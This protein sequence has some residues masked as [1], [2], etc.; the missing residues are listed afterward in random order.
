MEDHGNFLKS[1]LN[2]LKTGNLNEM[3]KMLN[4]LSHNSNKGFVNVSPKTYHK[5]KIETIANLLFNNNF[6]EL[7]RIL[8]EESNFFITHFDILDKIITELKL[9]KYTRLEL[10]AIAKLLYQLSTIKNIEI[11][12]NLIKKY[13]ERIGNKTLLKLNNELNNSSRKMFELNQ[14]N[15]GFNN[16]SKK[17]IDIL[18]KHL[19]PFKP[20]SD[21]KIKYIILQFIYKCLINRVKNLISSGKFEFINEE[22]KLKNRR[23]KPNNSTVQAGPERRKPNNSTVQAGPERRKPNNSTVQAGPARRK[24][25]KEYVKKVGNFLMTII[26]QYKK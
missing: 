12:Q 21:I 17:I 14:Y 25:N 2:K 18:V 20:N 13:E 22:L 8:T 1:L 6:I 5:Q 3:L 26:N 4:H 7:N 19:K 23:R 11:K 16:S 15:N 9:N 24:P 10:Y